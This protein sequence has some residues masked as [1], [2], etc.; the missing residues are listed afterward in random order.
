MNAFKLLEFSIDEFQNGLGTTPEIEVNNM[1]RKVKM[2][3]IRVINN[4]IYLCGLVLLPSG[5]IQSIGI[6]NKFGISINTDGSINHT[7][8]EYNLKLLRYL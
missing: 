4:R 7:E 2:L 8:H 1:V 6:W 3:S 5:E